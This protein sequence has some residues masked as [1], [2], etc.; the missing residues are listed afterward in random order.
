MK[1]ADPDGVTVSW[2]VPG[3]LGK[4]SRHARDTLATLPRLRAP[5]DALLQAF[6][7]ALE[8]QFL[9]VLHTVGYTRTHARTD[10]QISVRPSVRACVCNPL[11]VTTAETAVLAPC[12]KPAEGSAGGPVVVA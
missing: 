2:Q 11:C 8:L 12:R 5:L 7:R 4:R 6:Y 1:W 3:G 9:L 10:G